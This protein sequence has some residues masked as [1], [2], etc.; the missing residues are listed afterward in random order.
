M[1]AS[2]V[3][4]YAGIKVY[5]NSSMISFIFTKGNNCGDFLFAFIDNATLSNRVYSEKIEFAPEGANSFLSELTTI[6]K[7]G[8]NEN[9]RVASSE[10]VPIHLNIHVSSFP[11]PGLPSSV[12]PG[13]HIC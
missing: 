4:V 10:S 7:G 12:T 11:L 6:L 1:N 9:P 3:V 8:K 2:L 13:M 5:E